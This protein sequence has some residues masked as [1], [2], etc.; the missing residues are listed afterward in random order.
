MREQVAALL[1]G[2]DRFSPCVYFYKTHIFMLLSYVLGD[3]VSV[4]NEPVL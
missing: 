2:I 1:R 3:I 4:T